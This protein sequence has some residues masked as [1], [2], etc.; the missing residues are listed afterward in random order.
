M[1]SAHRAPPKLGGRPKAS[2]VSPY[3]PASP[4]GTGTGPLAVA[5][6]MSGNREG[7]NGG[8]FG[9][10][11]TTVGLA[12]A[13]GG[14]RGSASPEGGSAPQPWEIAAELAP[15]PPVMRSKYAQ[16]AGSN[17]SI[18]GAAGGAASLASKLAFAN[19]MSKGFKSIAD[20]AKPAMKNPKARSLMSATPLDSALANSL[21]A[22]ED[23][24][25]AISDGEFNL[26]K[27]YARDHDGMVTARALLVGSTK[28][29]QKQI[30]VAEILEQEAAKARTQ[31]QG[32]QAAL[33]EANATSIGMLR[34]ER[35]ALRA[36]LSKELRHIETDTTFSLKTLS[37]NLQR[38]QG[39]MAMQGQKLSGD[40][41]QLQEQLRET[42]TMHQAYARDAERKEERL[43]GEIARLCAVV[44]KL[45]SEMKA[46]AEEHARIH[47]DV[48]RTM[49][50]QLA[51]KERTIE[52]RVADINTLKARLETTTAT[53]SNQMNDLQRE[54]EMREQRLQDEN[55]QA[56]E[57]GRQASLFAA[58]Q[59]SKLQDE[60]EQRE[61]VLTQQL[62]QTKQDS[63][64]Q[65]E[66]LRTKIEKMRK[67]Q[68]LALGGVSVDGTAGNS[69]A[70]DGR[71]S[72]RGRQLLYWESLKSKA[73]EH[74]SMS[75]RGA[76]EF[77][78]EKVVAETAAQGAAS[79]GQATPESH[80]PLKPAK[81]RVDLQREASSS[82]KASTTSPHVR[83]AG[84]R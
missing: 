58:Q 23:S 47:A 73:Q 21:R 13:L 56:V 65:T 48:V 2:R 74:P 31:M 35:D 37:S 83:K 11:Q 3:L 63:E 27:M 44:E 67:L 14:G 39:S 84:Q 8:A 79:S 7:H 68:E 32:D 9:G 34:A 75:W 62:L 71:P 53:M 81:P 26:Q 12:A 22:R 18:G 1:P 36:I 59:L 69:G 24:K 28:A 70:S 40:V 6:A 57:R 50:G 55:N 15:E 43:S 4:Q 80:V 60:K 54:K 77:A 38:T 45:K 30:A 41:A 19:N 33:Y 20:L 25:R 46:A 82:V 10:A 66:S 72:T 51:D 49:S 78:H 29:L 17:G 61:R 16:P 76:N 64:N 42:Q 52:A 5:V